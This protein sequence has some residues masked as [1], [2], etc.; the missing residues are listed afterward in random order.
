MML[1][2]EPVI[3]D[4]ASGSILDE[5]AMMVGSLVVAGLRGLAMM[6]ALGLI[7]FIEGASP[8]KTNRNP[9]FAPLVGKIIL[10]TC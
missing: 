1:S 7:V 10:L 5:T 6:R 2:M 9:S 3:S 4:S 8:F